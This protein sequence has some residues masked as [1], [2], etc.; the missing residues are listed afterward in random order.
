MRRL[1]A[2][3]EVSACSLCPLCLVYLP[4]NSGLS[5]DSLGGNKASTDMA[6]VARAFDSFKKGSLRGSEVLC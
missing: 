6:A 2:E 3:E 5:D 1:S 4:K